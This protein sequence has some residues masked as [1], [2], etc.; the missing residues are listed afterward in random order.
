MGLIEGEGT[1]VIQTGSSIY[2]QVSH[3]T[4]SVESLNAITSFLTNFKSKPLLP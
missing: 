4:T 3:K 1:F 2:F